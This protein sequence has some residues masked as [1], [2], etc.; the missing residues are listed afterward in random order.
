MLT[1][2]V[3]QA[4]SALLKSGRCSTLSRWIDELPA[5]TL[6]ARPRLLSLQGGIAVNCGEAGQG[7]AL[8]NRAAALCR[9]T[10]DC[11]CLVL[12]RNISLQLS[13]LGLAV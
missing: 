4:G 1:D 8:L 3:E 9:E 11:L 7:L 13:Q 5:A 2:L 10:D 12:Q 6:A